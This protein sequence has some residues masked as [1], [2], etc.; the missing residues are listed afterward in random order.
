MAPILSTIT[1]FL[2]IIPCLFRLALQY[3][4]HHLN[5]PI[6]ILFLFIMPLLL[7]GC[8]SGLVPPEAPDR[9]FISGTVS[10]EGP[11]PADSTLFDLRFVALR[12]IPEGENDIINE[13]GQ[14]RVV[15]SNG[16]DRMAEQDSFFISLVTTG[17]YVY[18]GVAIQ[19]SSSAFDWLPV[20]LYQEDAGIFQVLPNDTTRIHIHVDFN[21]IPPFPPVSN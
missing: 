13:F 16:L 14:Q 18:S 1:F 11:W 6:L 9:G 20:G 19:Q 15:L 12:I 8:D 4:M 5:R 3:H 21:N 10:Y 2:L 7:T 17:P